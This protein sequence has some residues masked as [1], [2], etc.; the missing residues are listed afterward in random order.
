MRLAACHSFTSKYSRRHRLDLPPEAHACPCSFRDRTT[1]HLVYDC[2]RYH[3]IHCK[4]SPS[5]EPE[6]VR[7]DHLGHAPF[8][9]TCLS[10]SYLS[11]SFPRCLISFPMSLPYLFYFYSTGL[12]RYRLLCI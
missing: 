10:H 1:Y 8:P 11:A 9:T 7:F 5:A 4:A 3:Y 2:P 12:F 6:I